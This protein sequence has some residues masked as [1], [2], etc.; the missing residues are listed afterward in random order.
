MSSR[1]S[2][3]GGTK[4]GITFRRK[5]RSSRNRPA[6]ISACRSL[7]VAAR[8]RASTVM[9]VG[10][11]DR[12][13]RLFLEDAQHLGLRLEAHVADLVEEDRPAVGDLELAAP[14]GHRAGERAAHV[15]EELALDQ[16]LGNGRA[17][18]L[19]ERRRCGGG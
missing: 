4:I 7:F 13:H 1:R 6:R 18:H 19:D 15:A 5:Y 8:T 16:L 10:A 9:R 17:V 11:A 3:S 14:V 2:R 12:L